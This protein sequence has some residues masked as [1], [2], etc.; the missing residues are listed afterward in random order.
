MAKQVKSSGSS[1]SGKKSS[2][3]SA[4]RSASSS[5]VKAVKQSSKSPRPKSSR[6][7]SKNSKSKAIK[8]VPKTPPTSKLPPKKSLTSTSGNQTPVKSELMKSLTK[9]FQDLKQGVND[10]I[11]STYKNCKEMCIK[12]EADHDEN[13]AKATSS[14]SQKQDTQCKTT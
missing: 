3:K 2:S 4:S 5:K 14:H 11:L 8:K 7:S 9:V 1:E 13:L 12:V 10:Q 6:A